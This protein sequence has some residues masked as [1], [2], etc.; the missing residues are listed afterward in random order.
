MPA[1]TSRRVLLLVFGVASAWWITLGLM[2]ALTS[3]P[4]VLNVAQILGARLIIEA[5]AVDT[6]DA[7]EVIRVYSTD[8]IEPPSM[9]IVVANL[10]DVLATLKANDSCLI[11]LSPDGNGAWVVPGWQFVDKGRKKS[12]PLIYPANDTTRSRLK[13]ILEQDKRE[14]LDRPIELDR[15]FAQANR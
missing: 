5:R 3:N 10:K 12:I 6:D 8:H 14:I 4:P 1:L 13:Q 11:P 15:R 9:R 7:V 2:A